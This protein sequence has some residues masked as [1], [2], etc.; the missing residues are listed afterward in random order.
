M[1]HKYKLFNRIIQL[2][3][4]TKFLKQLSSHDDAAADVI[5]SESSKVEKFL[6]SHNISKEKQRDFYFELNNLVVLIKPGIGF[7]LISKSKIFYK[8]EGPLND[9]GFIKFLLNACMAYLLYLNEYLVL[10]GSCVEKDGNVNIF[11]GESSSGKSGTAYKLAEEHGFKIITD[12][13][14]AIKFSDEIEILPSYQWIKLDSNYYNPPSKELT[15]GKFDTNNRK[16]YPLPNEYVFKKNKPLKLK[17]IFFL[18]WGDSYKFLEL[19]EISSF[20]E[21]FKHTIRCLMLKQTAHYERMIL[22]NSQKILKLTKQYSCIRVSGD[23]FLSK[24]VLE[25][26]TE[27]RL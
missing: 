2:D 15:D 19:D 6:A 24:E 21:M 18:G 5:I 22:M 3:L 13:L 26:I 1:S 25:K 17:N 20:K 16:I 11:L 10:H 4:E 27:R 8:R 9:S 14:L 12:D 7:F 23:Q